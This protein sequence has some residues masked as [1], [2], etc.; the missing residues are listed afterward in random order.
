[1]AEVNPLIEAVIGLEGVATG[2]AEIAGGAFAGYEIVSGVKR[3][4][5]R[6]RMSSM[7]ASDTQMAPV[8]E[9]AGDVSQI[10]R[11][12]V[13]RKLKSGRLGRKLANLH[14]EFIQ[15][16]QRI[17]PYGINT[18]AYPVGEAFP[19]ERNPGVV[20]YN[21]WP[22]TPTLYG[23]NTG[24]LALSHVAGLAGNYMFLP[25]YLFDI[26]CW[27]NEA[28]T[29]NP[30][31]MKR[32]AID[33]NN[34]FHWTPVGQIYE[35]GA[36]HIDRANWGPESGPSGT[37]NPTSTEQTAIL[38]WTDIRLGFYGNRTGCVKISIE[39]V[40][41]KDAKYTYDFHP[42]GESLAA[43]SQLD[44]YDVN[45]FWANEFKRVTF[46][47]MVVNTTNRKEAITVLYHDSFC[48]NADNL[49]D[50]DSRSQPCVMK[51]I[52]KRF[53]RKV[54]WNWNKQA[55]NFD[56]KWV[57]ENAGGM[58]NPAFYKNDQGQLLGYANP[59]ARIYLYI[60]AECFNPRGHDKQMFE[61]PL[62]EAT[63]DI[64]V[65]NKWMVQTLSLIHI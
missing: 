56:I 43:M 39:M 10:N 45:E 9:I 6:R 61:A 30:V 23:Q 24:R 63:F 32:F 8:T 1:M 18:I 28:D 35:N 25:G 29:Y 47:P 37:G 55:P 59:K 50:G 17:Y 51:E 16:W 58:E 2:A 54:S 12:K 13:K 14:E 65:R 34:N 49:N 46:N 3:Y 60:K 53:N 26:T 42:D 31:P 19:E 21:A 11:V 62:N 48:I 41:F 4:I 27:R 38:K 7:F 20:N 36:F 52:F 57:G 44:R 33:N 15:R 64:I 22:A 40:Q 5:K